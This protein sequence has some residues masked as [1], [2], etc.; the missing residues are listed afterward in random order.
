M[1]YVLGGICGVVWGL[2]AAWVNLQIN[3]RAIAKNS[4]SALMGANTLRAAVDICALGLVFLLRK[5][6]PFRYEAVLIG[7]AISLSFFTIFSAYRLSAQLRTG[8]EEKK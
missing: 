7:T 3:K 6:L 1:G 5:V 4:T 8:A 2:A